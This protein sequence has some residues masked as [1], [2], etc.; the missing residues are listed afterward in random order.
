M[1]APSIQEMEKSRQSYLEKRKLI[2][3]CQKQLEKNKIPVSC[4]QI[5][6]MTEDFK[7]YLNEKCEKTPLES[8]KLHEISSKNEKISSKCLKVL[9]EREKIL[10]YQQK[11]TLL[12]DFFRK[13]LL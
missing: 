9:E 7:K 13:K 10:K 12:E 8:T 2:H 3:L 5:S 4:Y 6:P 11:D 1:K